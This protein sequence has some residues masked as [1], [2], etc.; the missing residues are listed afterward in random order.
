M[1]NNATITPRYFYFFHLKKQFFFKLNP[2]PAKLIT[3]IMISNGTK[4]LCRIPRQLG[5][6]TPKIML[7]KLK[8]VVL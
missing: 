8:K 7:V 1:K 3:Q 2:Y 4:F 6:T 5:R